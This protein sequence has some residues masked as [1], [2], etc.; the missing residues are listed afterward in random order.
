[1]KKKDPFEGIRI[2]QEMVETGWEKLQVLATKLDEILIKCP[3]K[4]HLRTYVSTKVTCGTCPQK[5]ECLP[6]KSKF[7]KLH[8][9]LR[10]REFLTPIDKKE[11]GLPR[12]FRL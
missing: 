4:N 11:L 1:M 5:E 8:S 12:K 10:K 7:N 2:K 6:V 3:K 9:K